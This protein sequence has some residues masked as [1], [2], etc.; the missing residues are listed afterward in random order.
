MIKISKIFSFGLTL[1]ILFMSVFPKVFAVE[2]GNT[3]GLDMGTSLSPVKFIFDVNQGEIASG[4]MTIYNVTSIANYVYTYVSNF[5]SDGVSGIPVF[6]KEKMEL[7]DS[8]KDWITFD[9]EKYLVENVV[10]NNTNA[11]KIKFNISIP[12]NAEYGG[13]YAAIM[14][15]INDPK[16][17]LIPDTGNIAFA[18]DPGCIILLNVKGKVSRDLILKGFLATDPF[19]K[20]K[21]DQWLFE[22]MPVEFTTQLENMGNSHTFP[23]G[24][25]IVYQG[26]NE[27]QKLSFNKS[28]SAILRESTRTYSTVMDNGFVFIEP[29]KDDKGSGVTDSNGNTQTKIGFNF[30][31]MSKQFIGPFKAKLLL[32]YDDDGQKKSILAEKEFWI[33]PWK[34]IL[35]VIV[36]ITGYIFVKRKLKSQD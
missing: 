24:N 33:L 23:I 28:E 7:N 10:K 30:D 21:N 32:V 11:T 4:E 19:L 22:W 31:L 5:K 26:D 8:L 18:A 6:I 20:E 14:V 2:E 35:F 27:V 13:H 17:S 1:L 12:K 36:L 29:T 9:K 16:K 15:S 25:I 3:T 34:L